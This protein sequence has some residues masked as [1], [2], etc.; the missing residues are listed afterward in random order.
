MKRSLVAAGTKWGPRVGYSRAV[1]VGKVVHI[2]GTSAVDAKGAVVGAGNAYEQTRFILQKIERALA[3][4][5]CTR[6]DVVRTRIY[7]TD[8]SAWK[9][10][11]RAHGEVFGTVMPA[12]TMVEVSRLI[13]PALMVEIEADAVAS[14]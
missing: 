10:I 4:L 7:T 9:E 14:D 11:G 2:A 12:S 13:E 8:I 1:R 3:E 5:G 6:K